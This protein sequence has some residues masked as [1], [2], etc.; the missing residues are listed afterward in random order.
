[1][2]KILMSA[3]VILFVAGLGLGGVCAYQ[4]LQFR[5][6]CAQIIVRADER[7]RTAVAATGTAKEAE[8]KKEADDVRK[9]AMFICEDSR[10]RQNN[11]LLAGS[12]APVLIVLAAAL[13]FFS[14]R[15]S[16]HLE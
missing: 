16:K 7:A 2:K 5:Q 3:A 15:T 1:M 9:G 11:Y 6:D 4:Y 14:R 10:S 12:G 8:L 13:L